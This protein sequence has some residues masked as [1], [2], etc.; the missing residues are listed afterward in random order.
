MSER[1][2]EP[3]AWQRQWQD[4]DGVWRPTDRF[5]LCRP[6]V[7]GPARKGDRRERWVEVYAHPPDAIPRERVEALVAKWQG[8]AMGMHPSNQPLAVKTYRGCANELR[9]TLNDLRG[10]KDE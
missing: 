4:P 1:E 2:T 7:V 9:D 5:V 10:G 6:A 3:V 8:K